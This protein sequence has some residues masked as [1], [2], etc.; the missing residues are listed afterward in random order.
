MW[1]E[2]IFWWPNLW[3]PLAGYILVDYARSLG[4]D[5]ELKY[6]FYGLQKD[7]LNV[8]DGAW[9]T[10]LEF[11][12]FIGCAML[13]Q[14]A[15]KC[16]LLPG[17]ASATALLLYDAVFGLVIWGVLLGVQMLFPVAWVCVNYALSRAKHPVALS[18]LFNVAAL[19]MMDY[20]KL[21]SSI[22]LYAGIVE[23]HIVGYFLAL[24]CISFSCDRS[25]CARLEGASIRFHRTEADMLTLDRATFT[26]FVA[27]AFYPPLYIGGPI[28][29]FSSFVQQRHQ[30]QLQSQGREVAW[31]FIM[32]AIKLLLF[33]ILQHI[34]FPS[35]IVQ[36]ATVW[37]GRPGFVQ[38]SFLCVAALAY[39]MLEFTW[40]KYMLIFRFFRL[41]SLIDGINP[42]EDI[43]RCMSNNYSV[44]GFWRNFHASYNKWLVTYIYIPL[45][46]SKINGI[47][48]VVLTFAWVVFTHD[49]H[50]SHLDKYPW[51]FATFVSAYAVE[52]LLMK[53][54]TDRVM[55]C[56]RGAATILVL[57][58][59]NML[60]YGFESGSAG[61]RFLLSVPSSW[62]TLLQLIIWLL[63]HYSIVNWIMLPYEKR[64]S[65]LAQCGSGQDLRGHFCAGCPLTSVIRYMAKNRLRS[66]A[67]LCLAC[68]APFVAGAM[69]WDAS[70]WSNMTY[71]RN[72]TRFEYEACEIVRFDSFVRARLNTWSSFG[73]MATAA[74][75][76]CDLP[77]HALKKGYHDETTKLFIFVSIATALIHAFWA[78]ASAV[79]HASITHDMNWWDI[80]AMYLSFWNTGVVNG[81]IIAGTFRPIWSDQLAQYVRGAYLLWTIVVFSDL[82]HWAFP[83]VMAGLGLLA[84]FSQLFLAIFILHGLERSV[85]LAACYTMV[86]GLLLKAVDDTK[87]FCNPHHLPADC[88]NAPDDQHQSGVRVLESPPGPS[89]ASRA[90]APPAMTGDGS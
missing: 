55:T 4:P 56:L 42:P 23:W 90:C 86:I 35:A 74:Y 6:S 69:A 59:G 27:Y 16:F 45:G 38:P 65:E 49:R 52:N 88:H 3:T 31:Y 1:V 58:F 5:L 60:S 30:R 73:F 51:W 68:L 33:E 50:L 28:L 89:S 47:R 29:R 12:P 18:W 72:Y 10:F 77:S 9:Q 8:T 21:P 63:V 36:Y 54:S 13:V 41:W 14:A 40:F 7:P 62:S 24:R 61:V 53:T 80:C 32:W 46:G 20:A 66:A 84:F 64:Q 57:E 22:P 70:A 26:A 87:R 17:G 34:L 82:L 2:R 44:K 48:N 71:K 39:W 19:Y 75:V 43:G 79:Y 81:Y 78:L 85:C 67:L 83:Y 11:L 25:D 76:I 37:A 15:G